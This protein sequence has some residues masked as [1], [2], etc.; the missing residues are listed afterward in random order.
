MIKNQHGDGTMLTLNVNKHNVGVPEKKMFPY[1][2]HM[3][4]PWALSSTCDRH[5]P[6]TLRSLLPNAC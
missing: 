5:T 3:Q 4:S 2:G 6:G 1:S